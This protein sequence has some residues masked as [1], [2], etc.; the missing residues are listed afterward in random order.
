MTT[1]VYSNSKSPISYYMPT[2]SHM[3]DNQI[4]DFRKCVSSVSPFSTA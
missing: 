3:R 2:Y 4:R 1:T